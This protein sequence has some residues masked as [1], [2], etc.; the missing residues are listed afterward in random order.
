MHLFGLIHFPHQLFL[1]FHNHKT[2]VN[3]VIINDLR[4]Y[5]ENNKVYTYVRTYNDDK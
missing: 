5:M 2:L 1:F 4:T 3:K